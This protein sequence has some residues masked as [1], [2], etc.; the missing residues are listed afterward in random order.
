[1]NV[2][3]FL[4]LFS[5]WAA[6]QPAVQA[7]ALVGSYARDAATE[8]SDVDLLILAV[9]VAKYIGDQSWVSQFGE[10]IECREEDWGQVISVR[11]FYNDGLEVEYGFSTPD[12]AEMPMD[13]GSFRVVSDG[14]KVLY[15][16]QDILSAVQREVLTGGE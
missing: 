9:D 4:E 8:G 15:D 16:P 2:S 12:W 11:T 3:A 10:V 6:T 1:M 13:A 5:H 14:M 7:V